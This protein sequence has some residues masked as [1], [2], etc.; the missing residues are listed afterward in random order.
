MYKMNDSQKWL[1]ANQTR[2]MVFPEKPE[3]PKVNIMINYLVLAM[4]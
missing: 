4:T 1:L 2:Y 3:I